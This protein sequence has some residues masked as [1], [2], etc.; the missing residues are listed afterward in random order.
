MIATLYGA[1][2][3]PLME[4]SR[5]CRERNWFDANH[6]GENHGHAYCLLYLD[7]VGAA[8]TNDIARRI[9]TRQ[10][11]AGA[12]QTPQLRVPGDQRNVW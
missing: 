5:G 12:G 8:A 6:G 7:G 9:E 10:S 2:A 3:A 11:D 1:R 4:A